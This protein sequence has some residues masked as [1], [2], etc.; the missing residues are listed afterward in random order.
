MNL[1][2]AELKRNQCP[3]PLSPK[4]SATWHC[5]E[6]RFS[7]YELGGEVNPFSVILVASLLGAPIANGV[8]WW[9]RSRDDNSGLRSWRSSLLFVGLLFASANTALYLIWLTFRLVD[10]N[11]PLV[12]KTHGI[13]GDIALF[14]IPFALLGATFGK[15]NARIPV[16]VCALLGFFLWVPVGIL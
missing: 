14:L 4:G 11:A 3:D 9:L 13:C 16:A 7:L 2:A 8:A 5:L 12:W 6:H 1:S 10:K 15:G